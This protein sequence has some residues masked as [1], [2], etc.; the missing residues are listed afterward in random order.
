[1]ATAAAGRIDPARDGKNL[2]VELGGHAGRDESAAH[3]IRL[4]HDGAQSHAGNDS[5]ADG[6]S[7]AV[8]RAVHG[9]L[10][11]EGP[12]FGNFFK[13]LRVAR[14]IDVV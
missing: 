12:V 2:P 4:Y 10:R 1:M 13:K 7:L 6:E 11:D 8:A 3:E 9:E 5:I 14:G